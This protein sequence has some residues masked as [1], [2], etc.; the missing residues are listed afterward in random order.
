MCRKLWSQDFKFYNNLP[1]VNSADL[2]N[3]TMNKKVKS[4]FDRACSS[5]HSR[6]VQL[7][8]EFLICKTAATYM[9]R[10][11]LLLEF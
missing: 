9:V 7:F 10:S 6:K 3:I 4:F 11:I 1:R 8:A 5:V 2:K